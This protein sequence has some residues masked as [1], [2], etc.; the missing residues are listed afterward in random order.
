VTPPQPDSLSA[1]HPAR[2]RRGSRLGAREWLIL[3]ILRAAHG[4]SLPCG[5]R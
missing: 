4:R 2:R 1:G 5:S 3:E